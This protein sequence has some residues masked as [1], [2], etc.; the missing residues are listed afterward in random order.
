MNLV[1]E[2]FDQDSVINANNDKIDNIAVQATKFN[3]ISQNE[4]Y[5]KDDYS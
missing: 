1:F 3:V 4:I 2:L 5:P